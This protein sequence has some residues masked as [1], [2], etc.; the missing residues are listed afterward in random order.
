[1]NE[2]LLFAF[3]SF[4]FDQGEMCDPNKNAN[5]VGERLSLLS[6]QRSGK[7]IL[8]MTL[9]DSQTKSL[10]I[11]YVSLSTKES[12]NEGTRSQLQ[13]GSRLRVRPC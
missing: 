11:V 9:Q 7:E 4:N 13:G 6:S 2:L 3:G 1:M 8:E 12:W 10:W 5:G